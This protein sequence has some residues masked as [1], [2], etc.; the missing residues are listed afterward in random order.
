MCVTRITRHKHGRVKKDNPK[1]KMKAMNKNAHA[2]PVVAFTQVH[3][4]NQNI[5][6]GKCL[7]FFS[8]VTT[9]KL[10]SDKIRWETPNK[11]KSTTYYNK[12]NPIGH[13]FEKYYINEF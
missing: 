1:L 11:G 3:T 2:L 12:R 7:H 13:V 6:S 4:Y 8:K 10:C 5:I 9:L